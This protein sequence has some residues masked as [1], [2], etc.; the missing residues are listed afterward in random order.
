MEATD[1]TTDETGI[2]PGT[3]GT[4]GAEPAIGGGFGSPVAD[5]VNDLLAPVVAALDAELVDV[6]WAGGTLR[7]AVDRAGGITTDSLAEINRAVSPILDQHDPVP[8]RYTLEVS[9][10][11]V[12]RPLRR[13]DHFRRAVGETIIV[14]AV[15]GIDPR[16]TKG[17][18]RS[19]ADGAL[20]IEVTEIDGVGLAQAEVHTV[21]LA[22]IDSAKT[23]FEWGPSPKPGKGKGAGKNQNKGN[24]Q[25]KA[26]NRP[27][28]DRNTTTEEERGDE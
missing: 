26:G 2:A 24:K 5:R 28:A 11:G 21:E 20:T 8:G 23:H 4:D 22:D 25:A 3:D 7:L 12:E 6:E 16:R 9:S 17:T 13:A 15:P 14:K 18:L 27:G 19:F 1:G 10:P